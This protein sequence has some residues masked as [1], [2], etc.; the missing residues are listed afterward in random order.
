MHYAQR[1]VAL[2]PLSQSFLSLA[3]TLSHSVPLFLSNFHFLFLSIFHSL[4]LPLSI[5]H[6]L[7]LSIFH[8][9]PLSLSLAFQHEVR[10]Y[11]SSLA[12]S[13]Q[14]NH[15]IFPFFTDVDVKL[16][17]RL[18][19][20]TMDSFVNREERYGVTSLEFAMLAPHALNILQIASRIA[21]TNTLPPMARDIAKIRHYLD[22]D[23]IEKST[24]VL[25]DSLR[26]V[27]QNIIRNVRAD[28][29]RSLVEAPLDAT[30]ALNRATATG[31]NAEKSVG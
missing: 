30:G 19:Y 14:L 31:S 1:L 29:A 20:I 10:G 12:P 8:S 25:P 13:L 17:P 4:F 27:F 5:F 26:M 7:F 28:T 11:I 21:R 24:Q 2:F 16:F 9:L 23:K 3:H 18:A 6:S 15:F 22:V